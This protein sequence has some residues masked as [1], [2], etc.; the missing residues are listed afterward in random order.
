MICK[1]KLLGLLLLASLTASLCAQQRTLWQIGKFDDSSQEF[2][3]HGI[4]YSSQKSDVVYTVGSSHA[5]DW[6]RFQPGPANAVAGGRL[7]P[8][9][10]NFTLQQAPRGLY[11]LRVAVLYETPRLSA[12][13]LS[14]NGHKGVF[15]FHPRLDFAAGDWEG[16]FVPQTSRDEKTIDIPTQ[17]LRRGANSLVFTAIDKPSAPQASMGDIAPGQSGIVYD[18]I[19]FTQDAHARYEEAT[20]SALMVPTIFY[21]KSSTGLNEIV[22]IFPALHA[23]AAAN[24]S[25]TLSIDGRKF[26]QPLALNGEFGEAHLHFPVPQWHGVEQAT[27]T[28]AGHRFSEK[29]TAA[30]KWTLDI[31]PQEHLDIGF[32]DYAPKVAELQSESVDG[33]LDIL[34]DYPNFRWSLDGS[35]IAQKYLAGRSPER[36]ERF[37]AAVRAGQIV[38]PPQFANQLTGVASLEG[39][40]R[41]LDYSHT[42][43]KKIDL[44][45]GAA[46]ITDVPS[47]S[48][49]Y[50]SVLHDAGIKYLAAGSNS[51]RAPI[52]LIGHWNEKSP[53]YWEGPDGGRVMM[54]YSRAYL[55]LASMYGNPPTLPA[56]KDAT[57]VFLQAYTRPDYIANSVIIYGSQLENTPLSR[58]QV[59]LPEE[60]A[61]GYAYPRMVFTTFKAAMA[62]L[63]KQFAGQLK[64][65][66]GDFGPYWEDGFASDALHTAI[67]RQ[68]QQRILTAEKMGTIPALLN[69]SLRPDD[70]RMRDAWKNML[71][72]DE[73][74]WEAAS[75][76]T[77]PEGDQSQ[78]QLRQKDLESVNAQNDITQSVERSWAQLES[79][80][81]ADHDSI[82][83]FNSLSWARSGWIEVDLP[84]GQM[85]VDPSTKLPVPQVIVRR[86][87]GASLP[88][89]GGPTN[90]VRFRAANIPAIGYRVFTIAPAASDRALLPVP[91]ASTSQ[92]AVLENSY[93][94]ITLDAQHGAIQSIYDKQLHRNLVDG[95][96]PFAFGAYVYV[97]G[98]DD[99]PWNSLY[100]YGAA[101]HLPRLEPIEATNGKIV[102]VTRTSQ[103][104][105]AVLTSS[106]PNT[107]SIRTRIT[108]PSREKGIE[109]T[110]SLHKKA[111]LRK[112]AAYFA[113]PFAGDH[114]AFRYDT[115]NG[116]VNPARD[117]L[118][119]GS[120]EWYAANHWAAMTSD[121]VTTAVIPEDAPLVTFGDIVRGKWPSGF[122]PESS[123]IFSWIMTNYWDTNYASS[124]GGNY[125]FRYRIVSMKGFDAPELTRLGWEAMTPLESDL[126][127]AGLSP[128]VLKQTS[129]SFLSIKPSA[130]VVTT[131]KLAEDGDGSILRL[132]ETAGKAEAV[133][134]S[135]P[136]LVIKQA[137]IC[138]AL[139][140][141]QSEL[142]V[143]PNGIHLSVPAF[144]IVTLR[145]KTKPENMVTKGPA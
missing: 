44:P 87:A 64:V 110:Y 90:R 31:V 105:T 29:L 120:R 24:G 16:T 117:E 5:R 101:Q 102:S 55:Q 128:H 126:V 19:E 30:K 4:N 48:W 130:V 108:L 116:W 7:H 136:S 78:R 58:A 9:Q 25:I 51:W 68:S 67:F 59:A 135:I 95:H 75:A 2:R 113:F 66:R 124:Q 131:W 26:T 12:L 22:D 140:D 35:W 100:R 118:A 43:A 77:Q 65:Y 70:A 121:D 15:Y 27:V 83:V 89:F 57:P 111:T 42:L 14:V 132:E 20:V 106:A 145:L 10:V 123:A 74:T 39:L 28:I 36:Q 125:I 52:Q 139:E 86:E 21:R 122:D 88:G 33:V 45:I 73:H 18:A 8:F 92:G 1:G 142:A 11:Q 63:D 107:P 6:L 23:G 115:Q 3:S 56:V 127:K 91:L 98:A 72:F 112:E 13:Q 80:I 137:W 143:G 133:H 47:Y 76:T 79:L 54:W 53:F 41:S 99:M 94:R 97:E 60:W 62:S 82:M 38:I 138:N 129:A 17:W 46:N 114:P 144:G 61:K 141:K 32:T 71:L 84:E 119:G 85:I 49:S 81:S 134:V 109:I 103:G 104:I 50:A 40:I 93:Y 34:H 69:P 96:N 37:L